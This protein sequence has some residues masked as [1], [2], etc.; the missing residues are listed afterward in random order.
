[1]IFLK[2]CVNMFTISFRNLEFRFLQRFLPIC[3]LNKMF[4]T[5][6]SNSKSLVTLNEVQ[7]FLAPLEVFFEN[8]QPVQKNHFKNS[9][10][11][12]E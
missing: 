1:M 12:V 4:L 6:S 7:I 3:R 11:E 8:L 10:N 2:E 5:T 9:L